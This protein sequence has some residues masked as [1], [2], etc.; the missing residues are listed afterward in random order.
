[1]KKYAL[2]LALLLFAASSVEARQYIRLQDHNGQP[3]GTSGNP[4]KVS[5]T[6]GCGSGSGTS[7]NET[8]D[9]DTVYLTDATHDFAMGCDGSD[10]T[11]CPIAG[12]ESNETFKAEGGLIVGDGTAT[13]ACITF[14]M[15]GGNETFCYNETLGAFQASD[16]INAQGTGQSALFQGLTINTGN[17]N[18]ADDDFSHAVSSGELIVNCD[19]SANVCYFGD[20][21]T[22]DYFT[23]TVDGVLTFTG[24]ASIA[25]PNG[26]APTVDAA[27]EVAVDTSSDQ[28]AYYG[29]AKR[30][31]TYKKRKCKTI[32]D[33]VDADDDLQLWAFDQASTITDVYCNVEGTT[34]PSIAI[35]LG[36]G[37][38]SLEAVTCDD[39]GAED[40]GSITNGTFTANEVLE[41]D[42]GAPSGTVDEIM[43]C[44]SYTI[45]SD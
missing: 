22:T 41:V 21:G 6:S 34:T 28:F 39:D 18:T 10:I 2:L 24:A 35:T 40:D 23:L 3:T 42:H 25:V 44:W 38:N 11:N 5:C 27:G 32:E 16:A 14:V 8:P 17:G 4:L 7:V 13:T 19:S 36:D 33:P 30:I 20:G 15:S 9:P 45:D 43:I 29:G 1:M 31:L 12:D 37:T 26:T